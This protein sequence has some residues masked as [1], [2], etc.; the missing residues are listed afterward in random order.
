ML[1]KLCVWLLILNRMV[2]SCFPLFSLG[3]STLQYVSSFRYLGHIVSDTL[4]DIEDI[5]REIKSMFFRSNV[6][7]RKF[8]KCSH[9]VKCTL[10]RSYCL[11]LYDIG[12]WH[13]Y[14]VTSINK[15]KSCCNKCLKSFFGYRRSY[16]ITQVL[17]E[18]GCHVLW[19]FCIIAVVLWIIVGKIVQMRLFVIIRLSAMQYIVL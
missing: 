9:V 12:L 7:I 17:L 19:Q 3:N 8:G 16:S 10:F 1:V 5:Q 13:K 15:F 11:S 14:T 18:T 2:S 6:L 4:C